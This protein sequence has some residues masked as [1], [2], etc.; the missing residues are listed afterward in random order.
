MR[1]AV[2]PLLEERAFRDWVS[3]YRPRRNR[4]T[5]LS[6]VMAHMEAGRSSWPTSTLPETSCRVHAR[7]VTGWLADYVSDGTFLALF[8]E[9]LSG[10]PEPIAP[11]TRPGPAADQPT[12]VAG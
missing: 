1:N 3:G 11:G 8:A 9:V 12:A 4:I 2:E 6:R 7:E 10:P 5:A